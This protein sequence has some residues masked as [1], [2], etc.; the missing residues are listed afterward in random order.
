MAPASFFFD[1]DYFQIDGKYYRVMFLNNLPA[2][3]TDDF[4]AK[5]SNTDFP[6]IINIMVHPV[7]QAKGL[8]RVNKQITGMEAENVKVKTL[9]LKVAI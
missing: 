8:D 6:C 9:L 3:I 5:I 4:I 1:R 2:S 7:E